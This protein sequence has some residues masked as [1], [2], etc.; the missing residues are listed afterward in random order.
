MA[1][2]I[3]KNGKQVCSVCGKPIIELNSKTKIIYLC[4]G[5]LCIEQSFCEL[6]EIQGRDD[7]YK[8]PRWL[9]TKL[10]DLLPNLPRKNIKG[11]Y[12][13][14]VNASLYIENGL[15]IF[16]CAPDSSSSTKK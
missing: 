9:T 6:L 16:R 12:I 5:S 4:I 10:K 13:Q 2:I 14:A 3:N 1:E 7:S 15:K 11:R 8:W